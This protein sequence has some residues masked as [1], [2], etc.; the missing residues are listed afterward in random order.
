MHYEKFTISFANFSF[1]CNGE[2]TDSLASSCF[3]ADD[4]RLRPDG[5]TRRQQPGPRQNNLRAPAGSRG[6]CAMQEPRSDLMPVERVLKLGFFSP[7]SSSMRNVSKEALAAMIAADIASEAA[8]VEKTRQ[9]SRK[10]AFA[11]LQSDAARFANSKR[12]STAADR[13]QTEAEKQASFGLMDCTSSSRSTT[14]SPPPQPSRSSQ[15]QFHELLYQ[16]SVLRK[17]ERAAW[18]EEVL[19]VLETVELHECTFTPQLDDNS[20]R[21]A[22]GVKTLEERTPEVIETRRQKLKA[23]TDCLEAQERMEIEEGIPRRP[24]SAGSSAATTV[25]TRS[26]GSARVSAASQRSSSLTPRDAFLHSVERDSQRRRDRL[27]ELRSSIN[28][29]KQR[30]TETFTPLTLHRSA[31]R[32]SSSGRGQKERENESACATPPNASKADAS[33][34]STPVCCS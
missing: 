15:S 25:S 4:A 34:R 12:A 24:L 22:Q 1:V 14:P 23:F 29:D 2:K 27:Q 10:D 31:A 18:R 33:G 30:T 11:R 20:R 17:L 8:T 19:D 7:P 26:R 13:K 16:E 5:A 3:C 9:K 21:L 6:G 28:F 32:R